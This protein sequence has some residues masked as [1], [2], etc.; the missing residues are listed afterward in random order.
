MELLR[1][2]G[3]ENCFTSVFASEKAKGKQ[4]GNYMFILPTHKCNCS[5]PD[6]DFPRMEA[7]RTIEKTQY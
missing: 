6:T 3:I 1:T 7:R 2:V 5:V 4:I